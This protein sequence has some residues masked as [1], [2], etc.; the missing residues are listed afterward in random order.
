MK[1]LKKMQQ[2]LRCRKKKEIRQSL[3]QNGQ[4]TRASRNAA[5]D[6]RA[7]FFLTIPE[8]KETV[9]SLT[10]FDLC[11][12][13][14]LCTTSISNVEVDLTRVVIKKERW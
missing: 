1:I 10:R 11:V 4:S 9:R 5:G 12:E 6:F 2:I 7:R 3:Y 13:S 14:V 8:Q